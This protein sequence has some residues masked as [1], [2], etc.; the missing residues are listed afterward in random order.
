LIVVEGQFFFGD[1]AGR[2]Q[3]ELRDG[4]ELIRR[5]PAIERRCAAGVIETRPARWSLRND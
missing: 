5:R 3:Q 2:T 1:G 4:V